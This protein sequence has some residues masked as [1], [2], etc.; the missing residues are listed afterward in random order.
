[1]EKK[2]QWRHKNYGITLKIKEVLTQEHQYS[3]KNIPVI[4][5]FSLIRRSPIARARILP[6]PKEL[7]ADLYWWRLVGDR[8]LD[9]MI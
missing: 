7:L 9:R 2:G 5:R 8:D 6:C 4:P 3:A 1:M